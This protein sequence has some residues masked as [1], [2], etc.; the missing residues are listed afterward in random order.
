MKI[1]TYLMFAKI[2][3]FGNSCFLLEICRVTHCFT[4]ATKMIIVCQ[5]LLL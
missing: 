2:K 5:Q 4:T 1:G 3:G